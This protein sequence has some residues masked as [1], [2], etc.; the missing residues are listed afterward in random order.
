MIRPH[1]AALWLVLLLA[2]LTGCASGPTALRFDESL[3]AK[4]QDS[5]V[6]FLVLHF[7]AESL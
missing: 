5:R 6:Q 7:T 1:I 4:G 3:S 2:L